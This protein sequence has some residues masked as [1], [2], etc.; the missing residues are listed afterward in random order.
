[1]VDSKAFA[2]GARL[3]DMPTLAP[4]PIPGMK[5]SWMCSEPRNMMGRVLASCMRFAPKLYSVED[6][7][8]SPSDDITVMTYLSSRYD[9]RGETMMGTNDEDMVAFS[10]GRN[11]AFQK[12][13]VNLNEYIALG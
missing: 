5:G 13:N 6:P 1:M 8:F 3:E 4:F 10:E 7:T 2:P 12:F 11:K 9:G